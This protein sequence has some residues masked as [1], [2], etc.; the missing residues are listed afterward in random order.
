MIG[1]NLLRKIIVT[2]CFLAC[3]AWSKQSLSH[4][5]CYDKNKVKAYIENILEAT[6]LSVG[7]STDVG[8]VQLFKNKDDGFMIIITSPDDEEL[9]CPLVTGTDWYSIE[10][11]VENKGNSF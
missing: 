8:L 2:S 5:A 3:F 6:L 4:A 9:A 11:P 7:I 1:R 10:N